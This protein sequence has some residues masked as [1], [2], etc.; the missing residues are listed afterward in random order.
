ML[1]QDK[2]KCEMIRFLAKKDYEIWL[3][4]CK[5]MGIYEENEYHSL[6]EIVVNTFWGPTLF[7]YHYDPEGAGIL[8][9]PNGIAFNESMDKGDLFEKIKKRKIAEME[10]KNKFKIK[11]PKEIDITKEA[12]KLFNERYPNIF[13][14]LKVNGNII[15][16]ERIT[17]DR[18]PISG[19]E[20]ERDN[21]YLYLQWKTDK[22]AV[23]FGCNRE[24]REKYHNRKIKFI[25]VIKKK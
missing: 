9:F 2:E 21:G 17:K 14:I 10:A 18:C 1:V 5:E 11:I 25:G 12:F 24:C 4:N 22:W 16:L 3:N 23:F 15:G 6:E 8:L 13:M 19:K 20:H 7:F